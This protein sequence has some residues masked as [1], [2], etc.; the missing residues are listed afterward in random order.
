MNYK[1][2]NERRKHY[3]K[4]NYF[5]PCCVL[6]VPAAF[7][8]G[9]DA[10]VTSLD[11]LNSALD[12]A[13]ITTIYLDNDISLGSTTLTID[14]GVTIDGTTAKNALNYT[15][16]STSYYAIDVDTNEPDV[17]YNLELN[18]TNANGRGVGLVETSTKFTFSNSEMNVGNRG[19]GV[20][21][22]CD[23]NSYITISSSVIKNSQ[24]PAGET[25]DTWVRYGDTRGISLWNMDNAEVTISDSEILGFGYTIN[26]AGTEVNGIRDYN[27]TTVSVTNS[28]LKGWTA[29]NIWSCDTVFDIEDSEL[30]GIN[31]SNGSSD[32]FAAIVFNN[33]IYGGNGAVCPADAQPNTMTIAGGSVGGYQ[34]GT[35]GENLIRVGNQLATIFKFESSPTMLTP[36]VFS[37]NVENYEFSFLYNPNMTNAD[38]EEYLADPDWVSGLENIRSFF[39]PANALMIGRPIY[40]IID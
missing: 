9:T 38:I 33:N 14:R 25:Y 17:L 20:V 27:G 12:D 36:I 13:G 6:H 37:S 3:E 28:K 39:G 4:T 21:N 34:Y 24:L 32:G 2:K 11:E 35:A 29:F 10:H 40:Q 30:R 16:T 7:A 5:D 8:A 1:I 19:I 22:S 18:A 26:L 31:I 15:G 23:T